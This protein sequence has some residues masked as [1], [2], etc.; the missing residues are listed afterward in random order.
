MYKIE[1]DIAEPSPVIHVLSN[2]KREIM[3]NWKEVAGLFGIQP[4]IDTA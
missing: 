2:S 4:N 1:E 3:L